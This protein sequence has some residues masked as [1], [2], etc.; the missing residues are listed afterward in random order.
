MRKTFWAPAMLAA[1]A[2]LALPACSNEENNEEENLCSGKTCSDGQ[3]CN[4]D[5]GLCEGGGTTV[6]LC[7]GVVCEVEGETCNPATGQCQSG[8]V[9]NPNPPECGNN[10]QEPGEECDGGENCDATC[11]LIV[12]SETCAELSISGSDTCELTGSGSKLLVRG[13]ILTADKVIENGS[14]LIGSNGVIECVGCDCSAE[15]AQVITCPNAVVSPALINAHEHIGYANA[16]PDSWGAERFDH[17]NDWRKNKNGHTNHNG[18]PTTNNLVGEMR[19]I[20]GGS[21]TLFG[22]VG[23]AGDLDG[24]MRNVDSSGLDEGLNLGTNKNPVYDTFPLGDS[25]GKQIAFGDGCSG[26]KPSN[27][28]K[29]FIADYGCPYGPHVA[30]GINSYALN[31]LY[32]VSGQD[33]DGIDLFNEKAAFIHG[34]GATPDYIAMMAEKGVKLIWSPRSNISLYGDTAQVTTYDRLGVT[35][36]MGTDWIYS[37]SMNMLRELQCIDY[38]NKNHYGSYF[39]DKKIWMMAT[40]NNAIALGVENKLGDLKVGLLGDIA[41]FRTTEDRQD[42]RAVIDAAAQDV[43]LVT[44]GRLVLYGDANLVAD[45]TCESEDVCGSAKKICA[46]ASASSMTYAKIKEVAKY[47]LFSCGI[48]E[49]EP[50]C[51]PQRTRSQDTTGTTNY[52]GEVSAT[53]SDGDGIPDSEDNC[54]TIFNPVRPDNGGK[55]GDYDGDNIGDV[56]DAYPTCKDNNASCPATVD[57]SARDTD[58]DGVVDLNDNCPDISN[59]EQTDSDED[60]KGD[61]CDTC[62]QDANPGNERCPLKDVTAIEDIQ[63]DEDGVIETQCGSKTEGA[64]TT[65]KEVR[66]EGVVTAVTSADN[67]SKGFFVQNPDSTTG[68]YA[69]I[70]VYTGSQPSVALHDKV[71]VQGYIGTYYTMVQM[72]GSPIVKVLSSDHTPAKAWPVLAGN[73]ATNGSKAKAFNSVLVQVSDVVVTTAADTNNIF[74]VEDASGT[75]KIDDYLGYKGTPT[76]G[77]A[78]SSITGVVVWD[79]N[80]SKIAPRAANDLVAGEAKARLSSL[81]CPEKLRQGASGTCTVSLARAVS[82]GTTVQLTGDT[83]VGARSVTISAGDTS[84]EFDVTM[85]S[86]ATDAL[87]VK[88]YLDDVTNALTATISPVG[89]DVRPTAATVTGPATAQVGSS[90]ELTITL[91]NPSASDFGLVLSASPCGS[92]AKNAAFKPETMTTT[93]T[94][95][96]TGCEVGAEVTVTASPTAEDTTFTNGS[97]TL[98]IVDVPSEMVETFDGSNERTEPASSYKDGSFTSTA[99]G[100]TWTYVGARVDEGISDGDYAID[101]D[102][103]LFKA[104]SVSGT[105][106]GGVGK[107]SV[108]FMATHTNVKNTRTVKLLV[109]DSECGSGTSK[110]FSEG[111]KTVTCENVNAS[112]DVAVKVVTEGS[113]QVIIDNLT[114]TPYN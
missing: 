40:I 33:P 91:D 3:T 26:Y 29:N 6:D 13:D 111:V 42:Y 36:G 61:I 2:M 54:P 43:L 93:A 84:A 49:D 4:P 87:T 53:D 56:C 95:D 62:P 48:P 68:E 90:V 72:T 94:L 19:M 83:G 45:S 47:D 11:H 44:R 28:A 23:G 60:G 101:G 89:T 102:G 41:V 55:Q 21:V 30:E 104:G 103:L 37:G 109:N 113:S 46:K 105:V 20:M 92:F 32:C 70:Y 110:A 82:E 80:D 85:A 77:D 27:K 35:I 71:S 14:V 112:G 1:F 18:D 75:V 98:T 16:K 25:G 8:P 31:E 24:L 9:V 99:T 81:T 106:T 51:V 34:V 39:S 65:D 74:V 86:D 50:T 12:A 52:A 108:E 15:D 100:I 76:V 17:R 58:G 114:W 66:I 88:A 73:V 10:V 79:W 69:G 78:Y 5:T 67:S 96:T 57:P 97:H 7:K 22:S 59:P 63:K 107:L 64:C 38:L